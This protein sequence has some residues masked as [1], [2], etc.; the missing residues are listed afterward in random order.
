MTDEQKTRLTASV[1]AGPNALFAAPGLAGTFDTM[2][3]LRVQHNWSEHFT[4]IL[5]NN[6]GWDAN[7]PG[8]DRLLVWPVPDQ[9]LPPDRRAST[10]SSAPSGSTTSRAPE[11]ASIPTTPR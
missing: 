11:P 5:Q 4:Q 1:Y 9:Y 3:E 7:T 10:P 6:M 2:V 8:R